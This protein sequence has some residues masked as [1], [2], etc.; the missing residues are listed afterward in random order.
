MHGILCKPVWLEVN[1]VLKFVTGNMAL[2]SI[3][4]SRAAEILN[5]M[6]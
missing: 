2:L 5:H 6:I 4:C 1:S 3:V